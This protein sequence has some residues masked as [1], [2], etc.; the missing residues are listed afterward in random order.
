MWAGQGFGPRPPVA[1]ELG[2]DPREGSER[3][4]V[5]QREP[6]RIALLARATCPVRASFLA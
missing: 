5:V 2:P 6:V 3:T 4:F 1:F